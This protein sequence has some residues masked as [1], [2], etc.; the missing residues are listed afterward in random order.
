MKKPFLTL[1]TALMLT[2]SMGS[3]V[4]AGPGHDHGE[5][6]FGSGGSAADSFT[7]DQN[8]IDNLDIQTATAEIKPMKQSLHMLAQVKLLPENQAI[9]TPHFAGK[10]EE[11]YAKLGDRMFKGDRLVRVAPLT[12]GS[13]P[14]T[15]SAPV[16]G[17]LS[18]QNI[19]TGQIVQPGDAMMKVTDRTEVLAKGIT[20]DMSDI[21]KIKVGQ[22]AA[23]KIDAFPGREFTGEVQRID[24]AIDADN[25]TFSVY[26]LI[27]NEDNLLIPHMQGM[28][29]IVLS[30]GESIPVLSVP[31]MAVLGS[32]GQNFIYVRDGNF[33]EKRNVT[34]GQRKNNQQEIIS[35]VFP[36]E[37]VVI[38]GNY[39]LQYITPEGHETEAAT[40]DHGHAH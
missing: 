8:V 4:F 23:L 20:Y 40:N 2:A 30:K 14:V 12:V 15:L 35:G 37:D 6:Q 36:G 24:Q 21:S 28:V 32:V 25:R 17:V 13:G 18:T 34:L 5:S 22:K 31:H 1:I 11:I 38:Q 16:D 33:F 3:S 7:L 27:P 29:D 10:V 26:A 39:Q 19:V 9:I